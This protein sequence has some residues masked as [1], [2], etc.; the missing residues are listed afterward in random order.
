MYY[1]FSHFRVGF[2]FQIRML[3]LDFE[4]LEGN[5]AAAELILALNSLADEV[6]RGQRNGSVSEDYYAS[7]GDRTSTMLDRLGLGECSAYQAS[8]P[9]VA[10]WDNNSGREF[11]S[12]ARPP[13][14][15]QSPPPYSC[16][17]LD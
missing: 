2:I 5:T 13:L 17:L 4:V 7:A 15:L 9:T 1:S 8:T 11:D 6:E 16:N 12:T 10:D 3:P 14:L